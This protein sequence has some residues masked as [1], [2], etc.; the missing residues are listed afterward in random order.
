MDANRGPGIN[1]CQKSTKAKPNKAC[2][3]AY[4]KYHGFIKQ[5]K[6]DLNNTKYVQG[7]LIDIHGQAHVEKYIE[8]GYTV[9]KQV[10]QQNLRD[11]TPTSI[12]AIK[13]L[14]P[15]ITTN[16]L[17]KGKFSLGNE[18]QQVVMGDSRWKPFPSPKH[19]R[20]I[21]SS[22]KYFSGGYTIQ[23]Y[24]SGNLNAIQIEFPLF[25]RQDH[26]KTAEK[27]SYA[28]LNFY[29]KNNLGKKKRLMT[30]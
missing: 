4:K 10:F 28:I 12:S 27:M 22:A 17:I 20:L 8:L 18:I 14:H 3:E 11:N 2:K 6:N 9:S 7:L 26:N 16:D 29:Q 30:F 13:K 1:S 23:S 24:G 25:L 19:P 21:P 5:F 15:S